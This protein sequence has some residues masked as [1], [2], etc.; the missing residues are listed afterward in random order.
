MYL[1][2]FHPLFKKSPK[3]NFLNAKF[4]G[5]CLNFY[6]WI[7]SEVAFVEKFLDFTAIPDCGWRIFG[8]FLLAKSDFFEK[9]IGW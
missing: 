2:C 8:P 3:E 4:H 9:D 7:G 6:I 5:F 1:H